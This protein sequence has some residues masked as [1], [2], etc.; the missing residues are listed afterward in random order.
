MSEDEKDEKDDDAD[1][2]DEGAGPAGP[3]EG[4]VEGVGPVGGHDHLHLPQHVEAVHLVEELH[5]RPLDLSVRRSTFREPRPA[6]RV[7]LVHEDDAR[8][9]VL[10]KAEH[11]PHYSRT[12]SD[13]LVD[14][15]GS[16]HLQKSSVDVRR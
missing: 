4:G 10:G 16:Y 11:L 7:D 9:V 15:R 13:V 3:E 12:F 1:D 8:L 14:D 6:D 2:A 5:Q